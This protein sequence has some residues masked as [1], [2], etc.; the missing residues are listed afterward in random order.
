MQTQNT[1]VS[2]TRVGIGVP[3]LPKVFHINESTKEWKLNQT[4]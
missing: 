4:I 3:L 2:Q 1:L